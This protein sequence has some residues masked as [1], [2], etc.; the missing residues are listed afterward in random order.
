MSNTTVAAQLSRDRT[1]AAPGR[2]AAAA[3]NLSLNGGLWHKVTV[4]G[5]PLMSAHADGC[6]GVS[7]P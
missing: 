5:Y 2:Q 7:G 6:S 4:P 3:S 1:P